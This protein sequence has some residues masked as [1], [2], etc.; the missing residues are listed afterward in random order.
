[1]TFARWDAA[2][3][4]CAAPRCRRR[5]RRLPS[6]LTSPPR[7]RFCCPC[8][9]PRCRRRARRLPSGRTHCSA[10]RTA[11]QCILPRRAVVGARVEGFRHPLHHVVAAALARHTEHFVVAGVWGAALHAF[12]ARAYT[13][14]LAYWWCL[15]CG[16]R[17]GALLPT[18]ARCWSS[19]STAGRRRRRRRGTR[20][21][22]VLP[23]VP[24]AGRRRGPLRRRRKNAPRPALGAH[25]QRVRA[26]A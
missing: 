9:A 26:R 12:G 13:Q 22:P 25:P 3:H 23:A 4:S 20:G 7:R 14:L 10:I 21:R 2:S 5:A 17:S 18:C 15:L 6:G 8:A 11:E 16:R 1:M 19:G 24:G